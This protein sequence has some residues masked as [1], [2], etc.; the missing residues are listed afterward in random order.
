M[1]EESPGRCGPATALYH[2]LPDRG[3]RGLSL[4]S[5]QRTPQW[6]GLQP[7]APRAL[8]AVC[9]GGRARESRPPAE[10]RCGQY[11]H[12]GTAPAPAQLDQEARLQG[13]L[14][15]GRHLGA[16]ACARPNPSKRACVSVQRFVF[17]FT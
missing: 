5:Q 10:G 11:D 13:L 4:V 6:P 2:V 9:V 17:M 7:G 3:L 14:P 1:Q 12:P 15:N 8:S 16:Q